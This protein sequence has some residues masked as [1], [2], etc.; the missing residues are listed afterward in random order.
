VEKRAMAY[1][2]LMVKRKIKLS[3]IDLQLIAF[4]QRTFIPVARFSI[5]LIFFWFGLIKLVGL[6]AASPLAAALTAKTVGIQH[7]DLLFHLLAVMECVIGILF[8]FPKATR[9]VVPLLLL[10]ML[11]VCSPLILVPHYTWQQFGVPT[12]EGQY[13]LKNAVVIAV[14][15]GIA[16]SAKPLKRT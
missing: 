7:F 13:I 12:L 3:E 1:N 14:A 6:S 2:S 4:F 15:I 9:I 10:H 8:L 5:F 11:I 16:A